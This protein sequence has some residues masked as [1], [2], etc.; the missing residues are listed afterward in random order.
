MEATVS[1]S[2]QEKTSAII[3]KINALAKEKTTQFHNIRFYKSHQ[4]QAEETLTASDKRLQEID[5]QLMDLFLE[6]RLSKPLYLV[7]YVL[8]H[9][10]YNATKYWETKREY[11]R[12][13]TDC[14][15][16]TLENG[17]ENSVNAPQLD[18]LLNEINAYIFH[19]KFSNFKLKN[20]RRE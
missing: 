15:I 17:W 1:I 8:E 9:T 5:N 4:V 13:D 19:Q 3:A 14:T 10:I 18:N 16:N 6:L 7:E 2:T 20:I 12:F 11:L